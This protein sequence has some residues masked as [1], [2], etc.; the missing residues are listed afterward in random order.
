MDILFR[1]FF[2]KISRFPLEL[3]AT[4]ERFFFFALSLFGAKR[5]VDLYGLVCGMY[6]YEMRSYKKGTFPL[7]TV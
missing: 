1:I 2:R 6:E 4:K 3:F 5:I 7:P